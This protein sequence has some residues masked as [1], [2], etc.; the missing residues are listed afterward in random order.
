MSEFHTVAFPLPIQNCYCEVDLSHSQ[1]GELYT[2]F[3]DNSLAE[4]CLKLGIPYARATN[5]PHYP[6]TSTNRPDYCG[7][8][9]FKESADVVS[10]LYQG[11]LAAAAHAAA[12]LTL[13]RGRGAAAIELVSY[14]AKGNR[15][16]GRHDYT[17]RLECDRALSGVEAVA[18]IVGESV[19]L[20]PTHTKYRFDKDVTCEDIIGNWKDGSLVPPACDLRFVDADWEGRAG[21]VEDALGT[22]RLEFRFF[23]L[24]VQKLMND[25]AGNKISADEASRLWKGA[26]YDARYDQREMKL[27]QRDQLT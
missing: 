17:S 14:P 12:Q 13:V 15:V 6:E 11:K 18:G 20:P 26:S 10:S 9:V 2:H 1:I 8:V 21:L 16:H 19:M 24:A 23:R 4:T 5:A 7:I 25:A 3:N 22:L 27:A